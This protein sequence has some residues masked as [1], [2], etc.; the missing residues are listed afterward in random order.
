[1]I[2]SLVYNLK[3]ISLIEL[4]NQIPADASGIG[5][6]QIFSNLENHSGS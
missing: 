1:M 6:A 3:L 2:L 4:N 5:W